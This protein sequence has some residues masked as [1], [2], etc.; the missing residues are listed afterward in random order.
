MYP[1]QKRLSA[2]IPASIVN[3]EIISGCAANGELL[4]VCYTEGGLHL[5]FAF[6]LGSDV[7]PGEDVRWCEEN[8]EVDGYVT[9]GHGPDA[10]TIGLKPGFRIILFTTSLEFSSVRVVSPALP[11]GPR[12]RGI[13]S[14]NNNSHLVFLEDSPS[15][16]A[17]IQLIRFGGVDRLGIEVNSEHEALTV[18][19]GDSGL[20][21]ERQDSSSTCEELVDDGT[22]AVPSL[23]LACMGLHHRLGLETLE[24]LARRM[25]KDITGAFPLAMK[26]SE[27]DDALAAVVTARKESLAFSHQLS[28]DHEAVIAL[29]SGRPPCFHPTTPSSTS[30][31]PVLLD[32]EPRTGVSDDV[33]GKQNRILNNLIETLFAYQSTLNKG[34]VNVPT[35]DRAA[36]EAKAEAAQ[37]AERA[38]RRLTQSGL[39]FLSRAND[40]LHASGLDTMLYSPIFPGVLRVIS[41]S[42]CGVSTDASS[43]QETDKE[44]IIL[45]ALSQGL[46][47]R[48]PRDFVWT[49]P[50]AA[51][52][53]KTHDYFPARGWWDACMILLADRHGL[54]PRTPNQATLKNLVDLLAERPD[55]TSNPKESG[56]AQV[57]RETASG[58]SDV[59]PELGDMTGGTEQVQAV[60]GPWLLKRETATA[61]SLGKISEGDVASNS[62]SDADGNNSSHKRT[63]ILPQRWDLGFDTSEWTGRRGRSVRGADGIISGEKNAEVDSFC[64]RF[65]RRWAAVKAERFKLNP[66]QAVAAGPFSKDDV[67]RRL[68]LLEVTMNDVFALLSR[69]VLNEAGLWSQWI[70]EIRGSLNSLGENYGCTGGDLIEQLRFLLAHPPPLFGSDSTPENL[71]ASDGSASCSLSCSDGSSQSESSSSEESGGDSLD[72]DR[73]SP[74]SLDHK[75]RADSKRVNSTGTDIGTSDAS[76]SSADAASDRRTPSD[77]EVLSGSP[78][79][80]RDSRERI[81]LKLGS[82]DG[83]E[84]KMVREKNKVQVSNEARKEFAVKASVLFGVCSNRKTAGTDAGSTQGVTVQTAGEKGERLEPRAIATPPSP[85]VPND[86]ED[87]IDDDDDYVTFVAERFRPRRDDSD[88]HREERSTPT[89]PLPRTVRKRTAENLRVS[90]GNGPSSGLAQAVIDPT[91]RTKAIAS[92][93]QNECPSDRRTLGA[94]KGKAGNQ[95]HKK[96]K[97]KKG[98]KGFDNEVKSVVDLSKRLSEPI[99]QS[100]SLKA[101]IPRCEKSRHLFYSVCRNLIGCRGQITQRYFVHNLPT[102]VTVAQREVLASLKH[103]CLL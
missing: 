27:V 84:G 34:L 57:K 49:L 12:A 24:T 71:H 4:P 58:E 43:E 65:S 78:R 47:A 79:V 39:R 35:C 28:A 64:E 66:I 53:S 44:R 22:P 14:N 9:V 97:R 99:S 68:V 2:V 17:G 94:T 81:K 7:L 11:A 26:R 80:R 6:F 67:L 75:P 8:V 90:A 56:D 1:E 31:V 87:Y 5:D 20:R 76:Q 51:L 102:T 86:R 15:A 40:I 88:W 30:D 55:R 74:T 59:K 93:S 19:E 13:S 91:G 83:P 100:L 37:T 21:S 95:K 41:D 32:G 63:A 29:L 103:A 45:G 101:R 33:E 3:M 46:V 85:M 96:G 92:L 42:L 73:S 54:E 62:D 98:R 10:M 18:D 38:A 36:Q 61:K 69:H 52:A 25:C 72:Q 82:V 89:L 48:L 77:S 60:V 23:I 16:L 70:A 50:L